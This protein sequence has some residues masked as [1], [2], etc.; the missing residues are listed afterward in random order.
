MPLL[1]Q[2]TLFGLTLFGSICRELCLVLLRPN[3][4]PLA[5]VFPNSFLLL[6]LDVPANN[7][8]ASWTLA[9]LIPSFRPQRYALWWGYVLTSLLLADFE[10]MRL[11]SELEASQSLH[12]ARSPC[13]CKPVF[14]MSSSASLWD[15]TV[16][17]QPV[18]MSGLDVQLSAVWKVL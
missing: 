10:A 9:L 8:A 5:I 13:S 6:L 14:S 16:Y 18:D 17:L 11:Y 3:R 15:S 12:G 7:P 1:M 2:G 4:V